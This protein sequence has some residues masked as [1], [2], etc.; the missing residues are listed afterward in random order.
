MAVLLFGDTVNIASST[1]TVALGATAATTI[2]GIASTYRASKLLVQYCATDN[3]YFEFDE[4]TVIHDGTTAD[5][6]EYGQIVSESGGASPGIGTYNAYL[7]GSNVNIDITPNVA[8]ASTFTVN[9]IRVSIA[10]TSSVGVG[11]YTM[12][13]ARLNSTITSIA[14]TSSP[15]ATAVA[16]YTSDDF[17]LC[18][19]YCNC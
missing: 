1:A 8:L 17:G 15:V 4:L 12:N 3:S 16:Q 18:S 19:L 11:T 2:V 6:L 10:D 5:L 7:S 13:T 14:S 9:T